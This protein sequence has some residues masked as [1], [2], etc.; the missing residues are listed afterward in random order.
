MIEND[1]ENYFKGLFEKIKNLA[2]F[3]D[4]NEIILNKHCFRKIH[5]LRSLKYTSAFLLGQNDL[6]I[7]FEKIDE[8]A[9]EVFLK[10]FKIYKFF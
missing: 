10:I 2:L 6:V 4:I 1:W 8:F 3:F 7:T 5:L 9:I